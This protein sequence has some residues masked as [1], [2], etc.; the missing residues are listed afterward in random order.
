VPSLDV[1]RARALTPGC[2]HVVH[3]NHAGAS[4]LPQPVLDAVVGH[5]EREAQIGGYEACAE[6]ADRLEAVYTSLATLLGARPEDLALVESASAGW[7]AVVLALPVAAGEQVVCTRTEYGSNAIVLL[8]L[9]E[10]TGCEIVVVEDA[11]TGEVDLEAFEAALASGPVAFASL[12]HVPTGEGLVNPAEDVGRL[13]RA[14]G[15]PLVLD[16]CQSVG[17]LPVDVGAIGCSVLTASGRK[18]LRGPRGTGFLWVDPTLLPRLRPLALDLRGADWI[19]PDEYRMREDVRRFEQFEASY[20]AR[21]G[22][23]AAVDHALGWGIEAIEARVTAMAE[24]L[25]A[26]LA[27]IPGLS[28]LDRGTRRCG[29]TTSTVD[30]VA[31]TSVVERLRAQAINT[32]ASLRTFAQHDQRLGPEV[33]E[34]LRASVHCTTTDEELDRAAAAIREVAETR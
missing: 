11:P 4:L 23:G 7:D 2:E 28:V 22:L 29:I 16:A 14:A 25:R 3:L 24:G 18:Y 12:V 6:A 5:L 30:G 10:R 9:A 33:T 19:A 15:V 31:A 26:R 17:Q 21:L 1:D 13:C 32:S 34:L 20:A 27:E 8:Q